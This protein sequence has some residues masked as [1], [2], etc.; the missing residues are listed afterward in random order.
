MRHLLF[1][2]SAIGAFLAIDAIQFEGYY[3]TAVWREA[4]Y[5]GQAFNRELERSFR[6]SL[7]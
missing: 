2:A 5:R 7:W 4:Q 6:N 1:L 3:R